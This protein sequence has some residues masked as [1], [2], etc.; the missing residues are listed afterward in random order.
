MSG[1]PLGRVVEI[2]EDGRYL[3]KVRGFLTVAE[4]GAEIGRVALDD[5]SAVIATSP[6]T[7]VSCALLADLANRGIP[8]V[9]CG[10]NYAPAGMLWPVDGHHAQQRRIE[11]QAEA[12]RALKKRLW[13]LVVAAKIRAQGAALGAAGQD[14]GGFAFLARQVKS[15]D[16]DN[17]EAQA[18]RRYWPMMMGPAFRRDTSADGVNA[19]LNYGYAV[20]RGSTARAIVAAGLHPGL[21][22]FHRHPH[23]AMPLADDLME[24]FR[25]QVDLVVLCL[26][27]EGATQ[28][29]S[30]AKRRLAGVLHSDQ[31]SEAGSSPL[32]TCISRLA[33]SLAESFLSGKA[34]LV[35]PLGGVTNAAAGDAGAV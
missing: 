17:L 7:T 27:R 22:I 33:A 3:A 25:P 10:R 31:R 13:S 28:V 19:L 35:F 4:H 6:A 1:S 30:A 14:G 32:E 20:L 2:A 24:P 34:N 11:S 29:T 23:N 12:G 15:G 8:F 16:P 9:L 5:I 26:L 21:G 18:A